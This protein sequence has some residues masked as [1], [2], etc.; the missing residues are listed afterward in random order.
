MLRL[1]Y[2]WVIIMI[3]VIG[4]GGGGGGGGDS[5]H[6]LEA[7]ITGLDG[8]ITLTNGGDN[9]VIDT[10]GSYIISRLENSTKYE[11]NI[12]NQPSSQ[13]CSIINSTGTVSNKKINNIYV[14]CARLHTEVIVFNESNT[15]IM[16]DVEQ[17]Y[18]D[19]LNSNNETNIEIGNVL[20][21]ESTNMAPEGFMRKVVD[22]EKNNGITRLYTEDAYLTDVIENGGF[23]FKQRIKPTSDNISIMS[24]QE[25]GISLQTRSEASMFCDGTPTDFIMTYDHFE[26]TNGV[27]ING[28]VGFDIDFDLKSTIKWG[29]I[30][31]FHF[32]T[33]KN[34]AKSLS[35]EIESELEPEIPGLSW[36]IGEVGFFLPVG[37]LTIPMTA[38]LSHGISIEAGQLTNIEVGIGTNCNVKTGAIFNN[39]DVLPVAEVNTNFQSI[40]PIVNYN[41]HANASYGPGIALKVAGVAGP[42]LSLLGYLD[43]LADI[44][45]DPWWELYAGIKSTLNFTISSLEINIF[46]FGTLGWSAS[47]DLGTI[48]DR[49]LYYASSNGSNTPPPQDDEVSFSISDLQGQWSSFGL[50]AGSPNQWNGWSIKNLTIQ[51]DGDYS[52]IT[53]YADGDQDSDSGRVSITENGLISVSNDL[54]VNGIASLDKKKILLTYSSED[55]APVIDLMFKKGSSYVQNDLSGKWF[56]TSA[57]TGYQNGD[58]EWR[59][60]YLT[61][62]DQGTI[63]DS[64]MWKSDGT[65]TDGLLS[66]GGNTFFTLESNGYITDYN[67]RIR[68]M[69]S[70]DKKSGAIVLGD[71]FEYDFL[72]LTKAGSSFTQS[73]LTGYW[74]THN[75]NSDPNNYNDWKDW[76]YGS[77][78]VQNNGYFTF[79]GV[80]EQG[81]QG[82]DNGTI[83]LTSSE[84]LFTIPECHGAFNN[85]LLMYVCS[86]D[87][88][89][90]MDFGLALRSVD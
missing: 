73:D 74:R 20:F 16:Q 48:Y 89:Q 54:T 37:P 2:L 46:G 26:V 23:S 4:C 21:S 75:I 76:V 68:G 65:Y 27:H 56:F 50:Y 66:P 25:I 61:F 19:V 59:F 81:Y 49:Q 14:N 47:Y 79:T 17:N 42:S 29:K 38:S 32:I 36:S 10:D 78:H 15:H 85:D 64:V 5:L 30:E 40:G 57:G 77:I 11:V 60:G 51:N 44:N 35:V 86:N 33:E 55:G 6:E 67:S 80:D 34:L 18:I 72:V 84:G 52:M 1:S 3:G 43:F 62:N 82:S 7:T 83:T 45:N 69:L 22:I 9:V 58:S 88:N 87:D 31:Y 63:V 8:S 13:I 12:T 70:S 53:N 24:N 90:M 28:C 71:N 41:A 39:G